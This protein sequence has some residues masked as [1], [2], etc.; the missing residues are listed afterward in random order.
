MLGRDSRP[1]LS[2][3]DGCGTLGCLAVLLPAA[4]VTGSAHRTKTVPHFPIGREGALKVDRLALKA[5]FAAH[6]DHHGRLA[7]VSGHRLPLAWG[8]E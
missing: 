7:D 1:R 8:G 6:R 4:C 3:F 5:I 2:A